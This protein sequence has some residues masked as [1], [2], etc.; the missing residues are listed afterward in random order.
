MS[1]NTHQLYVESSFFMFNIFYILELVRIVFDCI[2]EKYSHPYAIRIL[3]AYPENQGNATL[4]NIDIDLIKTLLLKFK[5]IKNAFNKQQQ[6]NEYVMP[7]L[8]MAS[9][10]KIIKSLTLW[11][12]L[13]I[14]EVSNQ[15]MKFFR[16][17]TPEFTLFN[18][19]A[20]TNFYTFHPSHPYSIVREPEMISLLNRIYEKLLSF[21]RTEV[22][23][24]IF[25]D[26]YNIGSQISTPEALKR[27]ER[28]LVTQHNLKP[29]KW[30]TSFKNNDIIFFA[31]LGTFQEDIFAVPQHAGFDMEIP[32]DKRRTLIQLSSLSKATG[33]SLT[34]LNPIQNFILNY[35]FGPR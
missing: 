29:L 30:L 24:D 17:A 12:G 7:P 19:F 3:S 26:K 18:M 8:L 31:Y 28:S 34:E 4:N 23:F 2:I 21:P 20:L 5:Q 32:Q 10:E 1:P 35:T 25:T 11:S 13:P 9:Y 27:A 33:I 6:T 16:G 15:V 14:Q 22:Y